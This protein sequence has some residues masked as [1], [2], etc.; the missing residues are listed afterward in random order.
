M[1]GKSC[2]LNARK[3]VNAIRLGECLPAMLFV[4]GRTSA[5]YDAV[6]ARTILSH[7]ALYGT[8]QGYFPV[9]RYPSVE[10]THCNFFIT[11]VN[12]WILIEMNKY[13]IVKHE[14]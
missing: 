7:I 3:K 4:I 10:T 13:R 5:L 11:T 9:A 2:L 14:I 12:C 1:L 6:D 8:R